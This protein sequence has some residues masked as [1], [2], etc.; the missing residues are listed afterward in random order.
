ML[1]IL[2]RLLLILLVGTVPVG[3]ALLA[4]G[5]LCRP[6]HRWQVDPQATDKTEGFIL[7]SMYCKQSATERLK[8]LQKYELI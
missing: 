5:Q 4:M 2:F 7:S 6:Q 1:G 3:T 8:I